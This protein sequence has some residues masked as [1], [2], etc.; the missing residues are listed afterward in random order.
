MQLAIWNLFVL[1]FQIYSEASNFL[2]KGV[3]VV[4]K[5]PNIL[6]EKYRSDVKTWLP[7]FIS[8]KVLLVQEFSVLFLTL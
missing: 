8:L 4:G 3:V 7:D 5:S 6:T 2:P 1:I